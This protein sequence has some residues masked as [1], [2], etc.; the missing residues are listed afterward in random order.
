MRSVVFRI[1]AGLLSTLFLLVVIL[2]GMDDMGWRQFLGT[3]TLSIGFGLY[4]IF[5]DLGEW[6][7]ASACGASHVEEQ[8][9][10]PDEGK[11]PPEPL[12]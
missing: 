10:Q 12:S 5:P 4:A 3:I 9:G 7:I 6:F 2:G 8:K 11:D 1:L